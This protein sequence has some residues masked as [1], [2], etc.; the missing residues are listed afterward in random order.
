[1][2][3]ELARV[4]HSLAVAE[5]AHLKAESERGVAQEALVVAGE[6]CKKA[7]EEHSRLD[8]ER[9]ALVISAQKVLF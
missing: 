7:E 5:N 8:D 2:E 9:L 1:M 4:R 3:S 6:A